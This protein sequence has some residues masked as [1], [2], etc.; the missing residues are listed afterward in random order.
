M[1][2]YTKAFADLVQYEGNNRIIFL[3][4]NNNRWV[5]MK[6]SSYSSISED[7]KRKERLLQ[8]FQQ[9]YQLFG[10]GSEE[11]DICSVYFAVTGKC[12]LQCDFCTMNSGPN[13]SMEDDLT[14]DEIRNILIPKLQEVS[15]RKII[16]TGGEPVIRKDIFEILRIFADTF[17]KERILLQTNG[18]LLTEDFIRDIKPYVIAVEISIENI[19]AD[20]TLL[21]RMKRL[22]RCIRD[23]RLELSLS[24]VMDDDSDS[25][26]WEA[27]DLCHEYEGAFTL[28]IVALVGR[29]AD[30]EAYKNKHS[31]EME[32]LK[33]YYK[34]FSYLLEKEYLDEKFLSGYLNNLQPKKAC[35]AFG[36]ILAVHPDG[37]TFMC[38]NFKH[39]DYS[40]GNIRE[41]AMSDIIEDLQEKLMSEKIKRRFLVD[42]NPNCK[43]CSERFFCPGPCAA[44]MT[45]SNSMNDEIDN[46]CLS[47][48]VLIHFN[49]FYYDNKKSDKD[50]FEAMVGFLKNIINGKIQFT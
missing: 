27:I 20:R 35:G 47:K 19:F 43:L 14:M 37:T 38:G 34:Y 1:M 24:F 32:I 3:N 21:A 40:M 11:C 12:N 15:P 33:K 13:V 25:Y 6:K 49:M 5:R 48:R 50:N 22:F 10:A 28:R 31:D 29:A 26:L 2:G 44:E 36:K 30:S 7:P 17:G 18:L 39:S 9:D 42:Q 41:K 8:K 46:K 16:I 4:P 23:N 45:E